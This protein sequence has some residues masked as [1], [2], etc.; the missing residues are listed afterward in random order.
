[1][2]FFIGIVKSLAYVS[3]PAVLV[4]QVAVAHAPSVGRYYARIVVYVGTLLTVGCCGIFVAAGLSLIGRS[5]DV[6]YYIARLFYGLISRALDLHITVEGAEHLEERPT[7]LMANHQSMLDVL[8]IGRIM[9]KQ[10]AIMAKKS[11]QFT[12]LG[13]FM[14]LSG[15]IFIDRGNSARAFRSIDAAGATMRRDRTS[16]WIF[17]EGTRHLSKTPDMLN[18]KKGG[19]HLAINAGIPITPIVTQNYWHLYHKSVFE[20]GTMT[21]KVLPPIPT[22]GLTV[23]DVGN[24]ATSVREQMMAALIKISPGAVAPSSASES[25]STPTTTTSSSMA[26]PALSKS[27]AAEA[28]SPV[29]KS[30]PEPIQQAVDTVASVALDSRG[31]SSSL[32]SSSASQLRA[33]GSSEGAETEE[34]EGMILVG[35][36]N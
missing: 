12:P 5:T 26:P 16:L 20:S 10:T 33:T 21:V 22:K 27:S 3:V 13:P 7:V 31:S 6:N 4:R 9:P 35:R 32:A 19:F 8:V 28:S 11:L 34:D 30:E 24:L 17:P 15:A 36:P 23:A 18:L 25:S 2:S 14:S 29:R 1:M